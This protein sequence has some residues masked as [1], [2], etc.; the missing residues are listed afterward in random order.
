MADFGYDVS[1]YCGVDPLFGN[2]NDF[3]A[4]IEEAHK[5]EL[6]VI[7]DLVP[8]HSSSEHSWFKSSRSSMDNDYRG[9]YHWRDPAAD[10]GPPNNWVSHFGGS[11]WTFD[12][13]SGQYYLHLF[14]P[15]QPDLNWNNPK[16][17]QE[18]DEILEFWLSR[19]IDGFRIDV[20]QGLVKNMLMPNNPIRFPINEDMSPRQVFASFDH[21]YDLDQAGNLE[22]FRRWRNL[23]EPYGSLLLG[24]VYLRDNDPNRVSRYVSSGDA[25]HRAFY[26]APMH[27]PWEPQSMWDTFRDALDA[28]PED[29]SWALSSHDDP[30]APTR[31]GGGEEGKQ[32]ALAYSVLLF[33]LPGLPVLYQGDELGLSSIELKQEELADPVA[34]RN[35]I[36]SDGRDGARTPM[37]WSEGFEFGFTSGVPWIPIGNRT[38]EDTVEYQQITAGSWLMQYRNLLSIRK[39]NLELDAPLRWVTARNSD[40]ISYSRGKLIS[41]LN[42]GASEQTISL[43]QGAWNL[44]FHVGEVSSNGREVS[45]GENS[46]AVLVLEGQ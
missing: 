33:F 20:A 14:L 10:G 31:F 15:E 23:V 38:Y 30:R 29:L 7:I 42:V 16:V 5:Q 12:E 37:P 45:V 39:V 36:E 43:P 41:A 13:E 35:A 4:L 44:V 34:T 8:N 17:I 27:V 25:L 19:D 28:A 1:D 21:R 6:R 22:I 24:E 3:D 40:V 9:Y 2:L 46:A 18:F 26:F 11:A 32:R